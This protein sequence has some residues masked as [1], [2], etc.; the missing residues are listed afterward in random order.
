VSWYTERLGL[1]QRFAADDA[2]LT[3]ISVANARGFIAELQARTTR[4]PNNPF[5]KNKG[6][7][8]QG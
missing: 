7:R 5:Y 1:F 6:P 3:D 8:A 4:N 2:T